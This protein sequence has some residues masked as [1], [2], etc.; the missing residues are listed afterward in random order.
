MTRSISAPP[1]IGCEFIA[2]LLGGER[3]CEGQARRTQQ[4]SLEEYSTVKNDSFFSPFDNRVSF[5]SELN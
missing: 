4:K 3:H 5:D 2:G 1:S